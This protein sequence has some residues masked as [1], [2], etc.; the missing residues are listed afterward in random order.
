MESRLACSQIL[1]KHENKPAEAAPNVAKTDP[2][3]RKSAVVVT[4]VM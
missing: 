4:V 3:R 1:D 2:M